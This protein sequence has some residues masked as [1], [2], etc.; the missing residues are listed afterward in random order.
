MILLWGVE[1]DAPLALVRE[2]L[3]RRSAPL[4]FLCQTKSLKYHIETRFGR[5]VC[6][7][8]EGPG[9]RVRLEQIGAA[10]IRPHDFR[11]FPEFAGK[12]PE[13]IAWRHVSTFDD[14][15][16]SWSELTGALVLNRPSAMASNN[17]KPFQSR[18]I[19]ETGFHVPDTLLTTDP[20]AALEFA[21]GQT[22]VIYKSI[23]GVR[24]IVRRLS[25]RRRKALDDV[26]WCP[27]QFQ[28]WIEGT[29]YRVHVVGSKLFA[30]RILSDADDYRYDAAC[31][32][33]AELPREIMLRCLQLS[34]RF[35]LPLAGI[36]LRLSTG[37]EWFCFEV[38]PSPAYSCFETAS[39]NQISAAI[40]DLL[41]E[42]DRRAPS[43]EET[44]PRFSAETWT[45]AFPAKG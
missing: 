19:Q 40:A 42:A 43:P 21:S 15:L 24:S 45:M 4:L 41:V 12:H 28:Q 26:A 9:T 25:L 18:L 5:T 37:G 2:E 23:S 16:V 17:S 35:N 6:G 39:G 10:Y 44:R 11:K 38:N 20:R 30:C 1:D 31:M 33:P 14:I 34:E 36:D 7:C 29:D 32:E 22:P 3:E 13:S 8:I 27:T